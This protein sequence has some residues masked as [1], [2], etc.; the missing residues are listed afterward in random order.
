MGA[1]APIFAREDFSENKKTKPVRNSFDW[2]FFLSEK[3]SLKNPFSF[4]GLF[5]K[6]LPDFPENIF[7]I[8]NKKNPENFPPGFSG[9]F[10]GKNIRSLRCFVR[11]NSAGRFV[12]WIT[13][14]CCRSRTFSCTAPAGWPGDPGVVGESPSVSGTSHPGLKS[15]PLTP[16]NT[17]K[18]ISFAI[19]Y[20]SLF[21]FVQNDLRLA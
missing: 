11:E 6:N 15:P 10:P 16:H 20:V 8:R 1:S 19:L 3:N 18:R 14:H 21:R 12:Q 2:K 7:K 5:Q 4:V 17:K 9:I 13:V